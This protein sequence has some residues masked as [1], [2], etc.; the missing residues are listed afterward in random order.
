MESNLS[1]SEYLKRAKT[2]MVIDVRSAFEY[3]KGHLPGSINLPLLNDEHRKIIGTIYK[4]EGRKAAVLK[5]FE[6]VGPLFAEKAH[7]L[8]A[9]ANNKAIGIYC[10]RGGMRTEIMSWIAQLSGISVFTLK[11]GYK[12]FRNEMINLNATPLLDGF[13]ISG[14]TGS[15]KTAIL[16]KLASNG[17][18]IIDLEGAASHKGS[19]FGGI[20]LP[21]QSQEMFEN[22]IAFD[23]YNH[24][25]ENGTPPFW[26]LED[27]SRMIGNK[28]IPAILFE[29]MQNL[30]RIELIV[31]EKERNNRLVEEYGAL[32]K[33]LLQEATLRLRKRLGDEQT[34][35][36]VQLLN[37]NKLN[38]WVAILLTYYD[39]TYIHSRNK[40]KKTIHLLNYSW[41]TESASFS[42]LLLLIEKLINERSKKINTIQ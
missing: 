42:Q 36:A 17:Y 8:L 15:G 38:E 29:S 9:L 32:D 5:G 3:K 39:K 22:L 20:G 40:T 35:L 12:A 33:T 16:K 4:Q 11:G 26:F 1:I 25:N 21:E 24:S 37:E 10:W 34:R 6:L 31:N 27:E 19:S 2:H 7:Q 23:R 28:C 14:Q 30:P 41:Q 13:V 18:K